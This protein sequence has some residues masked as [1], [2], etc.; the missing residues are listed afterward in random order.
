MKAIL[1]VL[2][3][4]ITLFNSVAINIFPNVIDLVS[5]VKIPNY[6]NIIHL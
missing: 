1:K 2:A 3:G 4:G 5:T 6:H